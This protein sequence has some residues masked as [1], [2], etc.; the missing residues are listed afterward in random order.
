MP[1]KLE[2]TWGPR[3]RRWR[4]LHLGRRYVVSCRQ[5]GVPESKD[6]SF[7]A[8]NA[9]WE[10]KLAEIEA[11]Q[12]ARPYAVA[13]EELR[14]RE[15]WS[16]RHERE[17][18]A[19]L[20]TE[21][22]EVERLE[23][24]ELHPSLVREGSLGSP[25]ARAVWADRLS[26]QAGSTTPHNLT[27]GGQIDRWL[28]GQE[29]R[30][31]AGATAPG[32]LRNNTDCVARFRRFAGEGTDVR[33]INED[34]VERYFNHLLGEIGTLSKS[35]AMKCFGVSRA[36][37]RYSVERG[38]VP[39]PRNLDSRAFRFNLGAAPV[40]TFTLEEFRL[41]MKHATGQTPLHLL[42]MANCG[43]TQIDVAELR[44][45]EVDW[46]AGRIVR[47]RSKTEGHGQVPVVDYKLWPRTFE[48]LR[49]HRSGTPTAL[50]TSSGAP[51]VYERHEAGKLK[52]NDSIVSNYKWLKARILKA[53][54]IE[55]SKPL[56]LI[57][58]TSATLLGGSEKYGR[59][60][61]LFL[62]HS[63]RSIADKHYVRPSA[64]LFDE[65]VS[66]L[67]GQYGF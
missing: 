49:S 51:W 47:K 24:G 23:D 66:W 27:I 50:L 28:E 25:A 4:K 37:I 21:I 19:R 2:M 64:E 57:R 6:A 18:A 8:A 48:L 44:D 7:R 61:Q 52:S 31:K 46:S 13:V 17:T 62:G 42:L 3:N 53:E 54:G 39:Q 20:A 12:P 43:M 5:L 55:F 10:A 16:L 11:G 9:W 1:V 58:K 34:L 22:Q 15:A 40:R 38:L 41:L 45:S 29:A 56:K 35:Y 36:F 14:R 33:D 63:P 59:Y 32:T 67:G 60:A 30:V 26:R 65:A